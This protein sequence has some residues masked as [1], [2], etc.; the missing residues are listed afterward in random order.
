MKLGF[1]QRRLI[2]YTTTEQYAEALKKGSAYGGVTAIFDEIPYIKLFL[3]NYCAE[4]YAMVGPIYDSNGF[5]FVSFLLMIFLC[6]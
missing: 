3:S 5:G 1:N 6:I 2:N 4:E